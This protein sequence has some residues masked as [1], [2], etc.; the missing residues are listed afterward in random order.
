M[1]KILAFLLSLVMALSL[2]AGCKQSPQTP[3]EP[4]STEPPI[5]GPVVTTDVEGYE[6]YLNYTLSEDDTEEFYDILQDLENCLLEGRDWEKAEAL[7]EELDELGYYFSDQQSIAYILMS[8]DGDNETYSDYYKDSTAVWTDLVTAYKEAARRVYTSD[9]ALKEAYFA[10]WTEAELR[11]MLNHTEEVA[12]LEK[13]NA[14]I[15]VAFRALD[16]QTMQS[17]MIPLYREM[18][19]N[20]NR[21]AN[22]AGYNNYYE[23]AYELS[24]SRDYDP[25]QVQ[26]VRDYVAQYVAPAFPGVMKKAISLIGDLEDE[27]LDVMSELLFQK[28]FD[29]LSVNYVEDYINSLPDSAKTGMQKMF[30]ESRAIFAD[31]PSAHESAFTTAVGDGLMCYFGPGYQGTSTAIHELGHFYAINSFLRGNPDMNAMSLDLAEVHSQ[32]NEWLFTGYLKD[33]LDEKVFEALVYYRMYENLAGILVQMCVDDFEE[34]VYTHPDVESLT[35]EDFEALMVQVC[36][37]YG[38]IEFIEGITDIQRYWRMVVLES[39]V[40]YISY[41]VSCIAAL[42]IYFTCAEDYGNGVSVYCDLVEGVDEEGGFLSN[43]E[44][45]GLHGPFEPDVYQALAALAE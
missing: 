32:G 23:Y 35:E 16:Q 37:D 42:D 5:A 33:I 31:N 12:Q 8:M 1:K 45:V 24:Y 9:S 17:D 44:R 21:I 39:P 19:L 20:N 38:G 30:L 25:E 18:V 43:L 27:Q 26:L 14:E 29:E 13:R 15:L 34:L 3:S 2:L 7:E 41:A 6:K 11:E 4:V 36:K 10:D 40:Y 22:I 28:N